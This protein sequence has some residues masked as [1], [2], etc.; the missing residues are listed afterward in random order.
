MVI[1]EENIALGK[2]K[3]KKNCRSIKKI[4]ICGIQLL[5]K[6]DDSL[7][8]YYNQVKNGNYQFPRYSNCC[9]IC[10]T[11][12]CCRFIGYYYR[13]VIDE[14]GTYFKEFPIARYICEKKGKRIVEDKTFSL[15]PYQLVPYV[16]Y[17][18]DFIVRVLSEEK[19]INQTLDK[20]AQIS[21]SKQLYRFKKII[22]I[23]KEKLVSGGFLINEENLIAY[24]LS[25]QSRYYEIRGPCGLGLDY[26]LNNGQYYEN[27][28]FLFG[29]AS[30]FR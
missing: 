1:I 24:S 8:S 5:L 25:Y 29:C 9:P 26:Y 12:E 3:R 23:A 18:I 21:D 6:L 4:L 19:S 14:N 17:S 2:R 16:K 11:R 30:Q 7:S 20:Y 15:L 22:D 10:R 28:W 27:S 13:Q